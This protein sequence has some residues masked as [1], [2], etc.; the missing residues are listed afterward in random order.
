MLDTCL[1]YSQRAWA[2]PLRYHHPSC[3]KLMTKAALEAGSLFL[4]LSV[5]V[6]RLPWWVEGEPHGAIALEPTTEGNLQQALAPLQHLVLFHV[7]HLIPDGGGR[8]VP[9]VPQGSPGGLGVV[10]LQLQVLLNA[11]N[12]RPAPGMDA[13]VV[14]PA[15]EVRDVVLG[16]IHPLG[17]VPLYPLGGLAQHDGPH[18]LGLLGQREHQGAEGGEVLLHGAPGHHDDVLAQLDPVVAV[19]VLAL[20]HRL[21]GV[22]PDT[23]GAHGAE[24]LV[25]GLEPGAGLVGQQD[26]GAPTAEQ[27]V[28]QQHGALVPVVQVLGQVLGGHHEGGGVGAA[29][30]QALGQVNGNHAR[31]AP[32]AGEVVG[33]DP[34]AH[35]ELVDDHGAEA[36]GGAEQGA[37]DHQEVNGLG[38]DPRLVQQILDHGADD[39]VRFVAGGFDGAVHGLPGLQALDDPW[40]PRRGL[41]C[42]TPC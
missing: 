20:V 32:H 31:A 1:C 4:W 29:L 24:Q 23:L 42:S 30:H 17:E 13:E 8:G 38:L 11:V 18:H 40:G 25:L 5:P 27:G 10:G 26:G 16:H 37:V 21:V 6:R 35:A 14:N 34:R 19:L 41:A 9:V 39:K 12:H 22:L 2:T 36:G 15:L 33:D 7:L 3:H 28:L